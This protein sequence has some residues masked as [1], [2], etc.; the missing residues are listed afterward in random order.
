MTAADIK[1]IGV[2]LY[3]PGRHWKRDLAR[4]LG[5]TR[6]AINHW[7]TGVRSPSPGIVEKLKELQ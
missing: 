7:L 1:S 6:R 5:V 3:G 4:H 2:R